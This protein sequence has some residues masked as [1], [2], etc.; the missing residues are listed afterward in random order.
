MELLYF[1]IKEKDKPL[2]R[3]VDYRD[4]NRITKR[5]NAPLPRSDEMFDLL[6]KTKFFSKMDL[7]TGFH[8]IRVKPDD[9]EKTAFSTEYGKFEYLAMLMGLYNAPATF[10]ALINKIFY[11]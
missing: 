3:V 6:G 4:L 9:V 7:R 5:N 11:N 8:Q 1:F 2:R 10:Q